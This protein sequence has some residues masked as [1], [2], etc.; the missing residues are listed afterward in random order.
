MEAAL[1]FPGYLG[2]QKSDLS[3]KF[4]TGNPVT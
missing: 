1:S 4:M 2:P 3:A